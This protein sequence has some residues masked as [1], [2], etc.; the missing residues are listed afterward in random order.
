MQRFNYK[1]VLVNE[2]YCEFLNFEYIN[3]LLEYAKNLKIS[4]NFILFYVPGYISMYSK[5][6]RQYFEFYHIMNQFLRLDFKRL[7][8]C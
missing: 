4:E 6:F 8:K 3:F 5:E 2:S 7:V 1:D